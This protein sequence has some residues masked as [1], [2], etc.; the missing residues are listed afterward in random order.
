[1]EGGIVGAAPLTM[2][3]PAA[4]AQ[5]GWN[6]LKHC[7]LP[8]HWMHAPC[9]CWHRPHASWRRACAPAQQKGC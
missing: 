4:R 9:A 3:R 1:M 5:S 6:A 8:A 7:L 2:C